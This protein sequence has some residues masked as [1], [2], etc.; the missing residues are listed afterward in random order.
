[1][2]P[3]VGELH[4]LQQLFDRKGVFRYLDGEVDILVGG[5]IGHEVVELKDKAHII[6]AIK[7][8]L[9]GIRTVQRDILVVQFAAGCFIHAPDDIQQRT[10]SRPARAENYNQLALVQFEIDVF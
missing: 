9:V 6:S 4:L 3:A 10:F 2:I 7:G 5:E 8:Q 1:M